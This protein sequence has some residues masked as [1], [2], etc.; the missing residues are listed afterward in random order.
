MSRIIEVKNLRKTYAVFKREAGLANVVIS[1]FKRNYSEKVA[2]RNVSFSVDEGD[3][4]GFLGPNGAGKTTTLKM[5]SGILYPTAGEATVLGHVPWNREPAFQ[6]N[7]AIV[8]GQKAQL[9]FDLPAIDSFNLLTDIY[10]LNA[11]D[12]KKWINHL[13]SLLGVGDYLTT[14][15]RRLSLGERM[16]MELIAALIHK[17]KVLFL[18]EP[19]IGLDVV[20]Q[21]A[22]REFLKKY[23][24]EEKVTILLTSHYMEDIA[25]LCKRVIIIN[26]GQVIFDDALKTLLMQYETDRVLHM[27]FKHNVQKSD[28]LHYGEV[29]HFTPIE[30]TISVKQERTKEVIKSILEDL[31]L[32]DF[33][34]QSLEADDVIRKVFTEGLK[35]KQEFKTES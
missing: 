22:I 26:E 29:K 30:A 19:T 27:T 12:A 33:S 8:M 24:E 4:V 21:K 31:P 13:A 28:L 35:M 17:P 9:W 14:Q 16:K 5:L 10:D 6:K 23:N 25:E 20:S 32:L 15:V 34:F 3:F 1:L 7:M 2:V 11:N 18:D